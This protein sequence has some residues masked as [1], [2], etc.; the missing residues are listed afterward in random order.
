MDARQSE[1]IFDALAHFRIELPSWGF[2]NTGTRFGKFIQPAAAT[3][4]EEKFSDAGQVHRLTGVCPTIALH[5]LW[6]CPK[7]RGSS[8]EIRT[9]SERHGV[10]PGS[11]NPNLFQGQEYKYGSFGNPD[12]AVRQRA[13]QHT[14]DSIEIARRLHSR[15]ISMWF[16]DGSSYPG[17]A[18]IRQ[19]KKWFKEVLKESHAVL[20]SGQ[21]LLIEY[22]PFEPAFY[23]TDIADWGM[24]LLLARAAGP[25]ARVL[26]DTGH[27]YQAQNIEQIVAWLLSEDLLGGF[28]FNDRRY[29]D[30]DLTLGSIDPYQVFRIFAE[31]RHYEWET[32]RR[33]DIAYMVDQSHNLKNKIEAMIQTVM[34]AQQL[35]AKAALIEH[36]AL[37]KARNEQRLI[38]AENCLKDAFETDVRPVLREWRES[39]R[40]APD[41]LRA[42][43]NSGYTERAARERGSR[44]KGTVSSYA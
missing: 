15:D 24:A 6:D 36:E 11:I 13:L 42:F 32:G 44:K 7:G 2:A 27:H 16:A 8:D 35:Y 26:V 4:T 9:F 21:R 25:Q 5:V 14:K 29:A 40:L 41:P 30:D 23:H 19:R 37:E 1:K 12:P 31:I 18:N 39:R 28:H 3:S 17:T 10:L 34:T 38:D 22:K 33:A 20:S 43:R